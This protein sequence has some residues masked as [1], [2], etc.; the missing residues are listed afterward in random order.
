MRIVHVLLGALVPRGV[1]VHGREPSRFCEQLPAQLGDQR[2]EARGVAAA[3]HPGAE[4]VAHRQVDHAAVAPVAAGVDPADARPLGVRQEPRL[5]RHGVDARPGVAAQHGEPEL[6]PAGDARRAAAGADPAPRARAPLVL[7]LQ[8]EDPHADVVEHGAEHRRVA[9]DVQ[10]EAAVV[11]VLVQR[12]VPESFF[13]VVLRGEDLLQHARDVA[14]DQHPGQQEHGPAVVPGPVAVGLLQA[15]EVGRARGERGADVAVIG[16]VSAARSDGG[17]LGGREQGRLALLF[18]CR[19]HALLPEELVGRVLLRGRGRGEA[20]AGRFDLRS[21]I[22]DAADS[23]NRHVCLP[24]K[25][26]SVS[27]GP[28]V[29]EAVSKRHISGSRRRK[30]ERWRERQRE[31]ALRQRKEPFSFDAPSPSRCLIFPTFFP[32]FSRLCL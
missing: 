4:Q 1:P 3:A 22:D 17:S 26:L 16:R 12:Q 13:R 14:G 31:R 29:A 10:A 18:L 8:P 23:S 11:G 7:R 30:R 27:T 19:V 20:R 9:L 21:S 15:R 28:G 25:S 5:G 32:F 6:A 24:T 2:R